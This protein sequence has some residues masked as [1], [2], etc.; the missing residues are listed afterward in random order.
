MVSP[1]KQSADMHIISYLGFISGL[2]ISDSKCSII[3]VSKDKDYDGVI[4]HWKKET[5]FDISKRESIRVNNEKEYTP[6][7]KVQNKAE[8]TTKKK[9][10]NKTVFTPKNKALYKEIKHLVKTYS[11]DSELAE[12]VA[13]MIDAYYGPNKML[14]GIQRK[15]ID[16][17]LASLYYYLKPALG[18]YMK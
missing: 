5:G 12:T 6:K 13:S 9:V 8:S 3:I 16:L 14:G 7:K 18:K 4:A 10:Q 2:Y 17:N 11:N 1:G 15:L